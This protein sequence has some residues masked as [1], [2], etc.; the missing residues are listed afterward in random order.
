MRKKMKY[1]NTFQITFF[2]SRENDQI[3]KINQHDLRD[4]E[5]DDLEEIIKNL[6][7]TVEFV[8]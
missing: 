7:G 4:I 6:S 5:L 2:S 3:L 8:S 1:F